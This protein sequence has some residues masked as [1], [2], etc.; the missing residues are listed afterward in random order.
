[1]RAILYMCSNIEKRL[2]KYCDDNLYN[3]MKEITIPLKSGNNTIINIAFVSFVI[4]FANI[5]NPRVLGNPKAEEGNIC[6]FI[7]SLCYYIPNFRF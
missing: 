3:E 7:K 1:M 4:W 2:I 5:V 6:K